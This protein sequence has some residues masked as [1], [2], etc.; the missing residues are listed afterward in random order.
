MQ[1][2]QSQSLSQE[3]SLEKEMAAHT[4][5]RSWRISGT[6]GS[7]GLESMGSKRVGDDLAAKQQE[8]HKWITWL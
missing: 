5:I 6:E 1:E 7:G 8:M 2:T 3:D 4:C